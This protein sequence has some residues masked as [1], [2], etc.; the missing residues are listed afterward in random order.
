MRY[1]TT[2]SDR[3]IAYYKKSA[4]YRRANPGEFTERYKRGLLVRELLQMIQCQQHN[5]GKSNDNRREI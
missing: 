3:L 5:K 2:N 4:P 1:H